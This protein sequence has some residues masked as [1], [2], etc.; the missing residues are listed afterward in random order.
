MALYLKIGARIGESPFKD[1]VKWYE[2]INENVK[3]KE[4]IFHPI[5]DISKI[6]DIKLTLTDIFK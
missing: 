2:W 5:K 3:E 4:G 6:A 1:T